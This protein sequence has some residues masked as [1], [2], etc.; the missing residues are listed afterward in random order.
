[1]LVYDPH[2]P[3]ATKNPAQTGHHL[4]QV[5]QELLKFGQEV[6][7]IKSEVIPVDKKWHEAVSGRDGITLNA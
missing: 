4:D 3:N 7:D 2:S 1:M 6:A 5:K